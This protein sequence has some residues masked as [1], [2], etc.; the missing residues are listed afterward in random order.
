MKYKNARDYA[1]VSAYA[2]GYTYA[3]YYYH[4]Y[5]YA[6]AYAYAYAYAS[7]YAYAYASMPSEDKG[8]FQREIIRLILDLCAVGLVD[9]EETKTRGEVLEMLARK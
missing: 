2:R 6:C 1:S 8:W 3:Y 7:A 5:A 4:Y 9:V